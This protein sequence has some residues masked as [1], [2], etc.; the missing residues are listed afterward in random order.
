VSG[1]HLRATFDHVVLAE[2]HSP[3][4]WRG[5]KV[6]DIRAGLFHPTRV[7]SQQLTLLPLTPQD[8]MMVSRA[9]PSRGRACRSFP[10]SQLLLFDV[11]PAG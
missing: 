11:V 3:Y 1:E 6:Q 8:S 10:I 4:D 7:A 5:H 2:Y 9:R